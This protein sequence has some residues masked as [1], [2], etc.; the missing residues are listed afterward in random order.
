MCWLSSRHFTGHKGM[1]Q[2]IQT[3]EEKISTT[4][5]TLL[6]KLM[7]QKLKCFNTTKLALQEMLKRLPQAEKITQLEIH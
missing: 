5:T 3:D 7:K 1:A 2:Y 6:S 4:K